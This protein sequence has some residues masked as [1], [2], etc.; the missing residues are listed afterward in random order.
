LAELQISRVFK[1]GGTVQHEV[2]SALIVS[3]FEFKGVGI[4]SLWMTF[5]G[6]QLTPA[7]RVMPLNTGRKRTR[8]PTP[9]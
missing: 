5:E 8:K 4:C 3:E 9:L 7:H 6:T 1:D 2:I